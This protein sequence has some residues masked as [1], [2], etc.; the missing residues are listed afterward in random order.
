MHS[1]LEQL[2]AFFPHV[3]AATLVFLLVAFLTTGGS[4]QFAIN[5][6]YKESFILKSLISLTSVLI[7]LYMLSFPPLHLFFL[8]LFFGNIPLFY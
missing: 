3:R 7:F 1:T 5:L 6:V 2:C 4:F 8:F